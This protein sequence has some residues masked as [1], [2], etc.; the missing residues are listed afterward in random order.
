MRDD[1]KVL[2][3]QPPTRAV[4][5]RPPLGLM[6]ISACLTRAGIDN[7][8]ID[9]KARSAKEAA[10]HETLSNNEDGVAKA[11]EKYVLDEK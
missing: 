3:V 2:L 6:Y 1:R 8:I 4:T 9:I 5:P 10:G 7:D 11:V